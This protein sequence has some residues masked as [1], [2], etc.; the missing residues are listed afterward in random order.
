VGAYRSVLDAIGSPRVSRPVVVGLDLSLTSTGVARWTPSGPW[1]NTVTSK[2]GGLIRLR[3]LRSLVVTASRGADLV[4][5]ERLPPPGAL[6]G[7]TASIGERSALYWMV[8]DRLHDLEIPYAEVNPAQ[9][10]GYA[11]GVGGGKNATKTAVTAAVVRRYRADP[12]NDDEADAC[13]LAAMGLHHL[14]HA[15]ASVPAVHKQWLTAVRW[16]TKGCA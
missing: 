13:V 5:L 1:L 9:L 3:Q 16:P 11:L 4:V 2:E 7:K 12:T 10:K 8:L 14:G 6:A 15:P